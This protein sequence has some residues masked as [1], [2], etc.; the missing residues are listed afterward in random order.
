MSQKLRDRATF[1]SQTGSPGCSHACPQAGVSQAVWRNTQ[2]ATCS[3]SEYEHCDTPK[4]RIQAIPLASFAAR[5]EKPGRVR[6]VTANGASL[7]CSVNPGELAP[8][9]VRS[10]A[11]SPFRYVDA[12]TL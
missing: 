1:R 12:G 5:D 4:E 7:N 9:H 6:L 11:I 3:N 2:S 8:A 10:L